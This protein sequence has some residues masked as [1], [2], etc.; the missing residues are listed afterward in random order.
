[1][2]AATAGKWNISVALMH[3]LTKRRQ[4]GHESREC[5]EPRNL[6]NVNCN[7]CEEMGHFGRDCPTT[8]GSGFD[9]RDLRGCFKCD[10]QEYL[11]RECPLPREYSRVKCKTCGEMGHTTVRCKYENDAAY[12]DIARGDLMDAGGAE[13]AGPSAYVED[14]PV[15]ASGWAKVPKRNDK[16]DYESP[17]SGGGRGWGASASVLETTPAK[18]VVSLYSSSSKSSSQ[19]DTPPSAGQASTAP[20]TGSSGH[21][22]S[23]I[24]ASPQSA[25]DSPWDGVKTPASGNSFASRPSGRSEES[26]DSWGICARDGEVDQCTG[27]R[28]YQN[29][30]GSGRI[31]SDTKITPG[32]KLR[33]L[34]YDDG[35]NRHVKLASNLPIIPSP[36]GDVPVTADNRFSQF[37]YNYED[38]D[39]RRVSQLSMNSDENDDDIPRVG[40]FSGGSSSPVISSSA[41]PANL[42]P[43]GTRTSVP[44]YAYQPAR[45][46]VG[47]GARPFSMK[48][49]A[50]AFTNQTA[51]ASIAENS[52]VAVAAAIPLPP[53]PQSVAKFMPPHLAAA[54]AKSP[55]TKSTPSPLG[56]ALRARA[57]TV[58]K[59]FLPPH[60]AT[61]TRPV[62]RATD[63]P[64][65]DMEHLERT[66]PPKG[67][68]VFFDHNV[69]EYAVVDES[70]PASP[71]TTPDGGMP[72][73]SGPPVV[74]SW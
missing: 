17:V 48:P 19:V 13:W 70:A 71:T 22:N 56:S 66:P 51:P 9:D 12:E 5:P 4:S 57:S 44:A 27:N 65:R 14:V 20:R 55:I 33:P 63:L 11:S 21:L 2:H 72:P 3:L 8:G 45:G 68:E 47:G 35:Q 41:N 31:F 64:Y 69:A 16:I 39:D 30:T 29:S 52:S 32:E 60:M 37:T 38:G 59:P 42:G 10:S 7:A 58:G 73:P 43:D 40:G 23:G 6:G 36:L 61:P 49:T 26:C 24:N 1:M 46:P 53:T 67:A 18:L 50:S 34:F 62:E 15:K 54:N 74:N 28:Q 25:F